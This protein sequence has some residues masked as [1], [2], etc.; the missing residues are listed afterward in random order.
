M[1]II[2]DQFQKELKNHGNYQFP[3]L[4]SYEKLS[5][6][7]SGSFPW[8]WHPEIELTLITKGQMVYK[9]NR[10]TFHLQEGQA[11]FG[12]SNTLHSGYMESLYDCQYTSVTF[13]PKL[14][15]GF[16]HSIICQ[17]YV[18]PI[19]QDFSLSAIHFD[20]SCPWHQE[21][22][23][24]IQTVI[25]LDEEKPPCCELTIIMELQKIW[26]LLYLYQTPT[27]AVSAHEQAEYNR[28]KEILSYL[29]QHYMEKIS[30][31]DISAH[32]HLCESECSRIFRHC[33][34][35]SLFTF[36]QEYRIERSLE[37]LA[38][39]ARSITEIAALTGFSDSNY[40]SKVFVKL[41]GCSPR[42]YRKRLQH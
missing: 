26:Q 4:V 16:P 6:Y 30:L 18:E 35:V 25:R 28:I 41:K 15:Y 32:I 39:S 31:S 29:E 42:E 40:Y 19:T 22:I 36:L 23:A 24:S 27:S 17:K 20:Q 33:M 1:Q 38:D 13:D 37:Y 12:N 11:L 5:S 2:T 9:V 10:N 14:I 7:E 21:I 3:F 8:H 34:N